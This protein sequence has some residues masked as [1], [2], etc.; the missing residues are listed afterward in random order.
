MHSR[1][2]HRRERLA[3]RPRLWATIQ[4][5]SDEPFALR[6]GLVVPCGMESSRFGEHLVLGSW[7]GLMYSNAM[8]GRPCECLLIGLILS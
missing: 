6:V 4:H 1:S 7:T 8:A 2:A 5:L 3:K